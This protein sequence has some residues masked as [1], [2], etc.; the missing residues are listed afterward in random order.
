MDQMVSSFRKFSIDSGKFFEND[1]SGF[2]FID[3]GKVILNIEN[4]DEISWKQIEKYIAFSKGDVV[5]AFLDSEMP[6]VWQSENA[7]KITH[8]FK[9]GNIL[10][11]DV[12]GRLIVLVL[13]KFF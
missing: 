13:Q 1:C 7:I 2:R 12:F 9:N 4:N 10:I 6:L 3:N 11:S 5:I 8:I